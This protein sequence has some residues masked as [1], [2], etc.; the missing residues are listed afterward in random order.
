M[1]V[2]HVAAELFP[3]LKTGGLADVAGA[4]PLALAPLGAEVRVLL[5][6]FPAIKAGVAIE[7]E[8]AA[9]TA[10]G[11][12]S[13]P[14][15]LL[16][17]KTADGIA[18][19]IIDAP[20]LYE[21]PGNPYHDANQ[22]SYPDNHL[23]FALLGWVAAQLAQGMDPYWQPALVHA[24]DW[25]AGLAPAYL[26]AAGRPAKSIVT[27]HNLAYQG[28]FGR[29]CFDALELPAH[30]FDREGVEFHGNLSF[31]KAGL[32]FADHITTVSPTYA[33]EITTPEQGCGLEGLLQMRRASLSGIINGVDELVWNPATDPLLP[34][35]YSVDKL[36]GKARCKAALQQELG[37]LE[38]DE[39]PLFVV[40]SRL[41]DQKGL[42]V[43]LEALPELL[44]RGGQFALLGSGDAWLEEA[45][46]NLAH[47][48]PRQVAVKIGYDEA[49]SHRLIA[50]GDVIMVPSRFEPCGLTQLYGLK[51][52]TLPLV[53]RVGGLAD[54]VT[55]CT[56]ENL[57]DDVATGFVFDEL[58]AEDCLRAIRRAYALWARP[59]EWKQ[60]RKRAMQQDVAWRA[61]A[62]HYFAL[63]QQLIA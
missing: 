34:A 29:D 40:V 9:F 13:G 47:A 17:G 3:L 6:G 63:Y 39:P 15:R 41:T 37:L 18:T 36:A 1:R 11:G 53:R 50:G 27:V 44:A 45:F 19:Y 35:S 22:Q 49:F 33:R 52:G 16:F 57:S 24:H 61:S 43:L 54:T 26:A 14:V 23:R 30:F 4:L 60:V 32:H 25:H 56:L 2:L 42:P 10:L 51:Y 20:A 8:V 7:G 38:T 62:E 28:V 46:R 55:D 12:A 58:S 31:L 48:N 21:R 5:P 59:R